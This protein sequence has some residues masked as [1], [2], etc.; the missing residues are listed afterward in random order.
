[1]P[2]G[3]NMASEVFQRAMEQ[4]FAGHPCARIVDDIIVGSKG[5]K[6]HD[7]NLK[8]VLDRA[9][10]VK[11]R[12]NPRKCKFRLKEVSYVG[13]LFTDEG[14]KAD[15]TKITTITEMSP[16]EDKA[17]LQRFLGMIIIS[18]NSSQT[19]AN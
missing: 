9:R 12:L 19:L 2:F 17:A 11:L 15:P 4:I 18:A 10:Q 13:H 8:K 5:V 7:K 14:L 1:M 3:I 16:S 6:E